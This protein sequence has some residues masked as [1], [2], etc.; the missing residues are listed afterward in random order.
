MKTY[1][2]RA[3]RV[4]DQDAAPTAKRRCIQTEE[5]RAKGAT[6]VA[7]PI[8]SSSSPPSEDPAIFSSDRPD[9][10][11]D[12]PPSSPPPRHTVPAAKRTH[13]SALRRLGPKN[14]VA[15]TVET[16]QKR[17]PLGD[18]INRTHLRPKE[19]EKPSRL[20][21]MQIDLGGEVRKS[22]K[23]CGMDYIPSN[24]EDAAL[25]RTFHAQNAAG[26]D[27]GKTFAGRRRSARRVW[28]GQCSG[29]L[30]D[31]GD[32]VIM[33]SR[34]SLPAEKARAK[35]ILEIANAELSAAQ[36]ED[37][38]LWSQVP[39]SD[40]ATSKQPPSEDTPAIGAH[41]AAKDGVADQFKV[42][43]YLK[44]SRCVGLCLAERIFEAYKVLK[45]VSSKGTNSKASL[46]SSSVSIGDEPSP[47]ILGISRLWTSTSHRRQGIATKLLDCALSTFV[48]GMKVP[49]DAVAFSQPTESGKLFAESWFGQSNEWRVYREAG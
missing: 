21:Q 32:C 26:V 49:K 16:S 29:R 13:S 35:A 28:L 37:E 7:P 45:D 41:R 3:K 17:F 4:L 6:Q 14:F 44:G 40:T 39:A 48:Y 12:S 20:T 15:H 24:M 22:C 23:A 30:K 33:L 19:T 34:K 25:H 11:Y 2:R 46:E 1:S 36:I 43:I 42:Y 31:G 27:V 18:I 5:S 38:R 9:V 47:A 10:V 8:L